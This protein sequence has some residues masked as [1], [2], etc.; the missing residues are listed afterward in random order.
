M[1]AGLF[2]VV[3]GREAEPATVQNLTVDG[4]IDLEGEIAAVG[5]IAGMGMN[6][7]FINCSNGVSISVTSTVTSS[8]SPYTGVGG[9]LGIGVMRADITDCTNKSTTTINITSSS[10]IVGGILG[11]GLG[12]EKITVVNSVNHG[13]VIAVDTD[14][15]SE[16]GAGGIAGAAIGTSIVNCYNSGNLSTTGSVGTGG[17][18]GLLGIEEGD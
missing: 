14:G 15:G 11:F 8:D 16:N 18:F 10:P 5:G 13:T 12:M 4:T 1:A 17:I 6:A 7:S 2:A 9:I 3:G